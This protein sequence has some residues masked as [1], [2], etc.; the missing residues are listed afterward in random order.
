[1]SLSSWLLL[2][3]LFGG[4]VGPL[5]GGA[6]LEEVAI[7]V[8]VLRFIV[9]TY[10]LP[11]PY[12]LTHPDVGKQFHGPAATSRSFLPPCHPHHSGL[13]PQTVGWSKPCLSSAD[14]DRHLVTVAGRGVDT[15]V[16]FKDN[17]KSAA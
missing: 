7:G 9:R 10:F 14:S 15:V 17:I 12:F 4:C 13:H 5:G 3:V 6:Q 1:M 8:W 16:Y 2:A 11:H